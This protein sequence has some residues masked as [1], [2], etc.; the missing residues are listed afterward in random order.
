MARAEIAISCAPRSLVL[1]PK[2]PS[3]IAMRH[4]QDGKRMDLESRFFLST[5]A[6]PRRQK[7]EGRRASIAAVTRCDGPPAGPALRQCTT[8]H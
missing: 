1:E 4:G 8:G 3:I 2:V 5:A 6:R 7:Q